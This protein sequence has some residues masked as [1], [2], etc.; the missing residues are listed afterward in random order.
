MKL[1]GFNSALKTVGSIIAVGIAGNM[2]VNVVEKFTNK[3]LGAEGRVLTKVGTGV[4]GGMALRS[5]G[6]KGAAA[7][8]T[9]G[10]LVIG[11][12]YVAAK[13]LG[14]LVPEADVSLP[15]IGGGQYISAPISGALPTISMP[16]LPA[17]PV[18]A[19]APPQQIV[20]QQPKDQWWEG[21]LKK[22]I[23]VGGNVLGQYLGGSMGDNYAV[24]R[25]YA[26][27]L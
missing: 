4:I 19:P 24:Q 6:V 12:L 26:A 20:I 1:T 11:G 8:G 13:A 7:A 10:G 2:M 25:E 18:H 22:G 23:E 17:S 9:K 5:V 21:L 14:N 27:L 15:N 16:T 3:R